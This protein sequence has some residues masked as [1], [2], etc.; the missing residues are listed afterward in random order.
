MINISIFVFHFTASTTTELKVT[1]HHIKF[2]VI[3][4]E[5]N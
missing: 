1:G 4:E 5:D 2:V 3:E